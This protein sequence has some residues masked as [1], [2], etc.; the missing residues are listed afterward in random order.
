MSWKALVLHNLKT[1]NLGKLLVRKHIY[2]PKTYNHITLHIVGN[3]YY[4][5]TFFKIFFFLKKDVKFWTRKLTW[6]PILG[7]YFES[8]WQKCTVNKVTESLA[9][10]HTNKWWIRWNTFG[11]ITCLT[12][13]QICHENSKSLKSILSNKKSYTSTI[14]LFDVYCEARKFRWQSFLLW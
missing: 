3:S 12:Y 1:S 9:T 11:I 13:D 10:S 5:K 14:V 4:C 7:I 6:W 8:F 2:I